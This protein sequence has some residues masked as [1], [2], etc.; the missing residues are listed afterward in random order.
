MIARYFSGGVFGV[1]RN[2]KCSKKCANPDLPGSNSFRDPV[3][4]GMSMLTRL[5]NPVGTTITLSPLASVRSV[6]ANGMTSR[7]EDDRGAC[8]ACAASAA[9][10]RTSTPAEANDRAHM[11]LLQ[12][13]GVDL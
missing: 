1:P 3:C 6:A 9:V 2:I 11:S 10:R 5:G 12:C 13:S 7:D 8:G 4:T